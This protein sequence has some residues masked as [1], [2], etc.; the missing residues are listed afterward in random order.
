MVLEVVFD[1]REE[2]VQ[3]YAKWWAGEQKQDDAIG[4]DGEGV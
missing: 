4:A 1:D 3:R 2:K